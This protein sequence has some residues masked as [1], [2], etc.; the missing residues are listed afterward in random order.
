MALAEIFIAEQIK[1]AKSVWVNFIKLVGL[2]GFFDE[3]LY[4]ASFMKSEFFVANL[5]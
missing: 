3:M 2:V 1:L 5:R 4:L